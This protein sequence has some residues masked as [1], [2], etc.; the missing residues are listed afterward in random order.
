MGQS[1]EPNDIFS[2]LPFSEAELLAYIEDDSTFERHRELEE[3]LV[4]HPAVRRALD[5]MREDHLLLR[6]CGDAKAPEAT[7]EEAMAV[8]ER[9]AL[10][11]DSRLVEPIPAPIPIDRARPGRALRALA[12]AAGF[13]LLAGGASY[14]ISIFVKPAG[15]VPPVRTDGQ[16]LIAQGGA[17]ERPEGTDAP[18]LAMEQDKADTAAARSPAPAT[19][20]EESTTRDRDDRTEVALNDMP[21]PTP[22][23]ASSDSADVALTGLGSTPQYPVAT[24]SPERA[25]ELAREGRLAIY[26]T[27]RA[28]K[29]ARAAA[30]AANGDQDVPSTGSMMISLPATTTAISELCS[31]LSDSID[32][33]LTLEELPEAFDG[34]D[35]TPDRQIS[36]YWALEPTDEHVTVPVMVDD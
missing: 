32:G 26:L 35:R 10:L 23:D 20:P 5:A 36:E 11:G 13:L 29:A 17:R 24:I 9:D 27:C 3:F 12:M 33:R 22:K 34:E 8:L 25:L 31:T 30:L 6:Q 2:G 1:S 21:D 15:T 18:K 28:R 19:E 4:A 14:W 7:V 16:G